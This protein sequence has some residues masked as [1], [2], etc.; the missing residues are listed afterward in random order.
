MVGAMM[1]MLLIWL[2]AFSTFV[3]VG[4]EEIGPSPTAS[5]LDKYYLAPPS[6]LLDSEYLAVSFRWHGF[7]P[8]CVAKRILFRS[9][10]MRSCS[11]TRVVEASKAAGPVLQ[12]WRQVQAD[13]GGFVVSLS[14]FYNEPGWLETQL[15]LPCVEGLEP[16]DVEVI[17]VPPISCAEYTPP[18]G[19]HCGPHRG[20]LKKILYGKRRRIL[21][22]Y[23]VEPGSVPRPA[24]G[25]DL[26]YE[27]RYRQLS[28]C[29]AARPGGIRKSRLRRGR[30]VPGG[31]PHAYEPP[32]FRLCGA[33]G[34]RLI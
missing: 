12:Y 13:H 34:Y 3:G 1:R 23:G 28:P 4:C 20:T 21:E 9:W 2:L 17:P 5:L 6:S 18:L 29:G 11:A 8:R 30:G 33:V 25:S 16:E 15:N 32:R 7:Q 19:A 31:T 24:C 14:S 22:P 27:Y 10:G 26:R